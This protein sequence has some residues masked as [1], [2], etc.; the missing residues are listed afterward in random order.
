MSTVLQSKQSPAHAYDL[1]PGQGVVTGTLL[2]TCQYHTSHPSRSAVLTRALS[3]STGSIHLYSEGPTAVL[4]FKMRHLLPSIIRELES[5]HCKV[6]CWAWWVFPHAHPGDNE[7]SSEMNSGLPEPSKSLQSYV[8]KP[9][10]FIKSHP[11][12]WRRALLLIQTLVRAN[13]HSMLCTNTSYGTYWILPEVDWPRVRDFAIFWT[14]GRLKSM[15]PPWLTAVCDSLLYCPEIQTAPSH[16]GSAPALAAPINISWATRKCKLSLCHKRIGFDPNAADDGTPWYCDSACKNKAKKLRQTGQSLPQCQSCKAI[17]GTI[18]A[19]SGC[20]LPC[21]PMSQT[22]GGTHSSLLDKQMNRPQSSFVTAAQCNEC[23]RWVGPAL[24]HYRSTVFD[25]TIDSWAAAH[26]AEIVHYHGERS[27]F[28]SAVTGETFPPEKLRLFCES[29]LP[30]YVR[31]LLLR[32]PLIFTW[33]DNV[34]QREWEESSPQEHPDS[35]SLRTWLALHLGLPSFATPAS[36]LEAYTTD[37][38]TRRSGGFN[39]TFTGVDQVLISRMLN[40]SVAIYDALRPDTDGAPVSAALISHS[41]GGK[42]APNRSCRRLVRI[43]DRGQARYSALETM[44]RSQGADADSLFVWPH[45]TS[46]TQP[47]PAEPPV[48]CSNASS[49]QCLHQATPE[50]VIAGHWCKSFALAADNGVDNRMI[51]VHCF[52]AVNG[53]DSSRDIASVEDYVHL[54]HYNSAPVSRRGSPAGIPAPAPNY[55]SSRPEPQLGPSRAEADVAQ[56]VFSHMYDY[57]DVPTDIQALYD[58]DLI[59]ADERDW[60]SSCRRLDHLVPT[61]LTGE[62][63]PEPGASEREMAMAPFC[64]PTCSAVNRLNSNARVCQTAQIIRLQ[65]DEPLAIPVVQPYT[66]I[67]QGPVFEGTPPMPADLFKDPQMWSKI[68]K[69]S[70][71][72]LTELYRIEQLAETK[73]KPSHSRANFR[74][75]ALDAICGQGKGRDGLVI[76]ESELADAYKPW[77]WSL[78]DFYE[79]GGP[80]TPFYN[81][82]LPISEICSLKLK[83]MMKECEYM[84]YDDEQIVYELCM[85]GLRN[86]SRGDRRSVLQAN[87]KG[88]YDFMKFNA[89]KRAEKLG[90]LPPRLRDTA[91]GPTFIPFRVTPKNVVERTLPDGKIK[92][93]ATSDYGAPRG[94]PG[95]RADSATDE[96]INAKINLLDLDDFPPTAWADCATVGRQVAIIC[97]FGLATHKFKSDFSAYFETLPRAPSNHWQQ[98]QCVSSSGFDTDTQGVFGCREF[99]ALATRVAVFYVAIMKDRLRRLQYAWLKAWQAHATSSATKASRLALDILIKKTGLLYQH[100]NGNPLRTSPPRDQSSVEFAHAVPQDIREQAVSYSL[101]RLELNAS[102]DWFCIDVFIDDSFGVLMSFFLP[103]WEPVFRKT[104]PEYGIDV[105][106]DKTEIVPG[107]DPLTMLG[108]DFVL[109]GADR[110]EGFLIIPPEKVL[111]YSRTGAEIKQIAEENGKDLVPLKILESFMGQIL[112]ACIAI[113]GMKGDWLVL[114]HLLHTAAR[115]AMAKL[116]IPPHIGECGNDDTAT[117]DGNGDDDNHDGCNPGG[118][119]APA[120]PC[121]SADSGRTATTSTSGAN[122]QPTQAGMGRQRRPGMIPGARIPRNGGNPRVQEIAVKPAAR[123][124][125]NSII[126]KLHEENGVALFPRA[127]PVGQHGTQVVWRFSDAALNDGNNDDSF[128]GF[129]SWQYIPGS[130]TIHY[131]CGPWTEE[132]RD[133]LEINTLELINTVMGEELF[134]PVTPTS[135]DVIAACDNMNAVVHIL[136][137]A[138][139]GSGPLRVTFR[140]RLR[141]LQSL[142]ASGHLHQRIL[143]YHV[144]REFNKEADFLSR[145]LVDKFKAAVNK[146]FG[147]PM[148]FVCISGVATAYMRDTISIVRVAKADAPYRIAK[149]LAKAQHSNLLSNGLPTRPQR[150]IKLALPPTIDAPSAVSCFYSLP[151]T[152]CVAVLHLP[153]TDYFSGGHATAFRFQSNGLSYM[154]T[155]AHCIPKCSACAACEVCNHPVKDFRHIPPLHNSDPTCSGGIDCESCRSCSVCKSFYAET[156]ADFLGHSRP[157][158]GARIDPVTMVRNNHTDL[159]VFRLNGY[160]RNRLI[161]VPN[162]TVNPD[163]YDGSPGSGAAIV[164][165]R[166]KI[167]TVCFVGVWRVENQPGSISYWGTEPQSFGPGA[168]GSPVVD[169]SMQLIGIHHAGNS[170]NDPEG[171][172]RGRTVIGHGVIAHLLLPLATQI[173][174]EPQEQQ[175][176]AQL[177]LADTTRCNNLER[178]AELAGQQ[179]CPFDYFAEHISYDGFGDM[180]AHAANSALFLS[181]KA[182]VAISSPRPWAHERC[183]APNSARHSPADLRIILGLDVNSRSTS[184][185]GLTKSPNPDLKQFP[186]GVTHFA[187]APAEHHHSITD[188]ECINDACLWPTGCWPDVCKGIHNVLIFEPCDRD[189]PPSADTELAGHW[190]LLH[191]RNGGSTWWLRDFRDDSETEPDATRQHAHYKCCEAQD[192]GSCFLDLQRQPHLHAFAVSDTAIKRLVQKAVAADM[193]V[194]YKWPRPRNAF[195]RDHQFKQQRDIR[196]PVHSVRA[197]APDDSSA[198][199]RR[200]RVD[201]AAAPHTRPSPSKPHTTAHAGTQR[202]REGSSRKVTFDGEDSTAPPASAAVTVRPHTTIASAYPLEDRDNITAFPTPLYSDGREQQL[203]V[204]CL[205]HAL[206]NLFKAELYTVEYL[207][208]LCDS[209]KVPKTVGQWD[210]KMLVV[211][212]QRLHRTRYVN[213]FLYTEHFLSQQILDARRD[214]IEVSHISGARTNPAIRFLQNSGCF[215]HC[216]WTKHYDRKGKH[217]PGLDPYAFIVFISLL[218]AHFY[219][220]KKYSGI[221]ADDANL[222]INTDS[223]LASSQLMTDQQVHALLCDVITEQGGLHQRSGRNIV[224]ALPSCSEPSSAQLH[225]EQARV[226]RYS[227]GS[228]LRLTQLARLQNIREQRQ[229]L[230]IDAAQ[231]PAPAQRRSR[232]PKKAPLNGSRRQY[233]RRPHRKSSEGP[234]WKKR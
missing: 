183:G 65:P 149:R 118:S 215:E 11:R 172:I 42:T 200:R 2:T 147:K 86:R 90:N 163:Q 107:H 13:D 45:P 158:I 23:R 79:T 61:P 76:E 141:L 173:E 216:V 21:N 176:G 87:Y 161:K 127:G 75:S 123:F 54:A 6:S 128:V 181:D 171:N 59:S 27:S 148:T 140:R 201:R 217:N 205:K 168:S 193:N 83:L 84:A 143:G 40:K 152:R 93:R 134:S 108:L 96:S 112:F 230:E 167:V 223:V 185:S 225:A 178:R 146:R 101:Q 32:D 77:T 136:N 219:A 221:G 189:G 117:G 53:D 66:P 70:E 19:I 228:P 1:T 144:L 102:P 153:A 207:W 124:L 135:A 73:K 58:Q 195:F 184:S 35:L 188:A 71:A 130:G 89:A 22:C 8:T 142:H 155:C 231:S 100:R 160:W 116:A 82:S 98:I 109:D 232:H 43:M 16:H 175:I 114:L 157:I 14:S 3:H 69:L 85:E 34:S 234:P 10:D 137:G 26:G 80:C 51:C 18:C 36:L 33:L 133:N 214:G 15:S 113:P 121:A 37:L 180:L 190:T 48:Y 227:R 179:A 44:P 182:M 9:S 229:Q 25:G 226:I 126:S 81:S 49:S 218:P 99:P 139:A 17:P 28:L 119:Q 210:S 177:A 162:L 115:K 110:G 145:G 91:C 38:D 154:A 67:A 159:A 164:H 56:P 12:T 170:A 191:R 63:A 132:E 166:N 208:H 211:I 197:S 151:A 50:A 212:F 150:I 199:T 224:W 29:T 233:R 222:W 105:A 94:L 213:S 74:F 198:S 196:A 5:N 92:L 174:L 103:G 72:M 111:A 194:H 122:S 78:N 204:F 206:N 156:T 64:K 125:I 129:G 209:I 31:D 47:L 97:A 62:P 186:S 20:S 30:D 131:Y 57:P 52:V 46:K 165:C 60:R 169:Q 220:I 192:V 203:G 24:D 41:T 138:K 95:Y 55:P 39:S 4:V 202:R 187:K 104:W 7:C 68:L 120:P 88:F 106:E